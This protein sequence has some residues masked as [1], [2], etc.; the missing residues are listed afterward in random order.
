MEPG[1]ELAKI[2]RVRLADGEPM[3]VEEAYLVHR[4]CRA[5]SQQ[6]FVTNPIARS[7]STANYNIRWERARQVIRAINATRALAETLS[8]RPNAALLFIERV[9][10]TQQGVPVEFLRVYHRGDRYALHSELRG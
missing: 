6:D 7:S 3:S 4:L 5:S 8:V 10:Y 1:E 9:S 2:E